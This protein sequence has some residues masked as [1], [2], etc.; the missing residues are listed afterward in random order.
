[1]AAQTS[2]EPA[3][4]VAYDVF[5][6]CRGRRLNHSSD[7]N[8]DGAGTVEW[9]ASGGS[10]DCSFALDSKGTL[11]FTPDVTAI[12][13]ITPGGYFDATTDIGGVKTRLVIRASGGVLTYD[14][15]QNDRP[16]PFGPSGA[17]WLAG[18]LVGLDRTTAF[19]I[20]VRLPML[21]QS[22]G[23]PAVLDEVERMH[24]EYAIGR[25][26]ERLTRNAPLDAASLRRVGAILGTMRIGHMVS[27]VIVA[28]TARDALTDDV[29]RDA[30][31]RAA[32]TLSVDNDRA[33]SLLALFRVATLTA[34]ELGLALESVA[35]M[36]VDVEKVRVLG[37]AAEYQRI[38]GS[39]RAAFSNAAATIRD[40]RQRTRALSMLTR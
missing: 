34:D 22:G 25:Y 20:D 27:E 33:R 5:D 36:R 24:G 40:E 39:V 35:E 1:M 37:A 2:T 6:A 14:F 13:A 32:V 29:A 17:Q 11:T 8:D 4:L 38:D 18:L 7:R 16:V 3:R 12:A 30:F 28:V 31:V 15:F 23:A 21:M 19:A 9:T 10:S 26:L